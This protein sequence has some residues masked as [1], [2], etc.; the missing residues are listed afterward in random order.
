MFGSFF[1]FEIYI[2]SMV[3]KAKIGKDLSPENI[4]T[5]LKTWWGIDATDENI[6]E[7]L[8]LYNNEKGLSLDY[9]ISEVI[10]R[11]LR[12]MPLKTSVSI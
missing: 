11:N 2:L 12:N 7:I 10:S 9:A 4:K 5:Q 8:E 6:A 3:Q 1:K